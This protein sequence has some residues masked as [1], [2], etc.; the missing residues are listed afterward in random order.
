MCYLLLLKS[1]PAMRR[2]GE[3]N[4]HDGRLII[5]SWVIVNLMKHISLVHLIIESDY[6][7]KSR[8]IVNLMKH[9]S[10]V[11]LIIESVFI[12]AKTSDY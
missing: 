3:D 7:I 2:N 11:P 12:I 8:V 6:I 9:N 10:L 5:E 1:L 4:S